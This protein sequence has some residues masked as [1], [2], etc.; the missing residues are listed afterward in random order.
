MFTTFLLSM[1]SGD[2]PGA[3]LVAYQLG[4][5][6]HTVS[7]LL[8]AVLSHLDDVHVSRQMKD[9]DLRQV[10]RKAVAY[11]EWCSGGQQPWSSK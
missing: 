5:G 9:H 6:V 7:S 2:L 1:S 4:F 3:F 10:L 11:S 8:K